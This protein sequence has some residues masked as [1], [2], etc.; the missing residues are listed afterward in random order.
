MPE[1]LR[2]QEDEMKRAKLSFISLSAIFIMIFVFTFPVS[3]SEATPTDNSQMNWMD[4]GWGQIHK[5]EAFKPDAYLTRGELVALI[6]SYFDFKEQKEI[7]F[8]D[9]TPESSYYKEVSKAFG[10]GYVL[11]RENNMFDPEKQVTNVEAYIMISR[12]LIFDLSKQPEKMLIF[13]DAAE[14][15]SW[16]EKEVEAFVKEGFLEGKNK[17]KPFENMTGSG[18]VSLLEKT[19]NNS[20][21]AEEVPAVTEEKGNGV[22]PLNFLG[23]CFV[24]IENNQSVETGTLEEGNTSDEI[25]IKLVFDRG[26]VR[27]YWENNQTQI[28]LKDNKGQIIASEVFRIENSDAEKSYIFIKPTAVLKSGKTVNIVIGADLKANNGNTF[29]EEKSISFTVK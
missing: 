18:A 4:N 2:Q 15:P 8:D 25:I 12:I 11:G 9:V 13:K 5:G 29:G 17:I 14:V 24:T 21:T 10:A 3:A 19:K 1:I 16:A 20:E 26:V 23:A 28:S 6:N 27:D 22:A 7:S